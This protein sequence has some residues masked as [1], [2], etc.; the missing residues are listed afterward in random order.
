MI[1][2]GEKMIKNNYQIL[3]VQEGATTKEIRDAFRKLA[4]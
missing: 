2:C 4:L 3:G 1:L